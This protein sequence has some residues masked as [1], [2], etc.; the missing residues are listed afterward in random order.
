MANQSTDPGPCRRQ[1]EKTAGPPAAGILDRIAFIR[2]HHDR[3]VDRC[4]IAVRERDCHRLQVQEGAPVSLFES[5]DRALHERS[6]RHHHLVSGCDRR[7]HLRVDV[8]A[9]MD[10]SALDRVRDDQRYCVPA[11]T[12]TACPGDGV[13]CGLTSFGA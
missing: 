13:T 5:V 6:R 9:T 12:V 10:I 11:G 8:I 2:V 7:S 4:D 3:S 1:Q